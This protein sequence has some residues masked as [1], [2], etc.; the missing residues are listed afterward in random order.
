MKRKIDAVR[1]MFGMTKTE[2]ERYIK[3]ADASTVDAI[4]DAYED[5]A[6]RSFYAD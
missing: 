6:R 1:W 3:E 2:A 5:N 4:I